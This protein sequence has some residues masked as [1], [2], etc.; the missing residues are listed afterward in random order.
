MIGQE[1]YSFKARLKTL[2]IGAT[3][4]AL[5]ITMLLIMLQNMIIVKSNLTKRINAQSNIIADHVAPA[6]IFEDLTTAQ[7]LLNA[8]R[9]ESAI[10]LARVYNNENKI[11]AEYSSV[12]NAQSS[13]FDKNIKLIELTQISK[14]VMY[15][16][17]A[18][19]EVKLWIS[20]DEL[21]VQLSK[22]L[23]IA[24]IVL[25]FTL[26]L[27]SFGATKML[28]KIYKPI[29]DLSSTAR[30]VS[31]EKNYNLRAP[32][33]DNDEIGELS[34]DFNEML[35]QIQTRDKNLETQ[36]QERTL[37]LEQ[38]NIDLEQSERL[39]KTAF[40]SASIG[41]LLVNEFGEIVQVNQALCEMLGY[42]EEIILNLTIVDIAYSEDKRKG[43]EKFEQLV[44]DELDKF[45]LNK[46]YSTQG[47]DIIWGQINVSAVRDSQGKFVYAIAQ[48]QDIT[49]SYLLSQKL[50]YQASHDELTGLINRYEFE[51]R[52]TMLLKRAQ[53][54]N[55][56]HALL[57]I[58]LDQFKVINDTCGHVAGDDLLRKVSELMLT[59][60]RQSDTLAR[61]GGDEFG[62]LIESCNV[63]DAIKLAEQIRVSIEEVRF[64]WEGKGFAIG[65]SIG[66]I[67]IDQN[68][69]SV[70]DVLK[71]ADAA[72]YAAKDLGRNQV[73]LYGGENSNFAYRQGEM[74]WVSKIT[75]AFENSAFKLYA[76]P[77]VKISD[78][79]IYHYEILLRMFD[80]NANL[81]PPGAFIPAAER[82]NLMGKID[83]WV[84]ENTFSWLQ[85][86]RNSSLFHFS[87]NLSGMNIGNADFLQ[88]VIQQFDKYAI[89]TEQICFEITETAAVSNL[90]SA[91]K[92]ILA[93]QEKG[94]QFSLDDFGSGVSSFAYLK[95]FAVDYLK[96]DG[97]FVKDILDDP[98]D[99]AMVKSINEI[100]HVMGKKT[101][102][103]F[104]ESKE[105]FNLL[106]EL[107]VDYAQGYGVGKPIPIDEIK[108]TRA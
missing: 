64:S 53:A 32:I 7:D 11:F 61:L 38:K 71:A 3:G 39:F 106:A 12:S 5:A 70:T 96:I 50:T 23:L 69:T 88:F 93:L 77:I 101:I 90:S 98:I 1:N 47:G 44:N 79:K 54:E 2:V 45:A 72:C 97:V 6:L 59:K 28:K 9:H 80:D 92:F 87:I 49:E 108:L 57:Y 42:E 86:N 78:N 82:Y 10:V 15:N 103:E 75:E 25:I 102:A 34:K 60:I 19:G 73:H 100:S 35:L 81:I 95:N 48:L 26:L 4:I 36:V 31:R 22:V 99:K 13:A 41:V 56:N 68:L 33:S 74:Q 104:V 24:F 84:I 16:N 37:Q 18:I 55:S 17:N 85:E 62:L 14:P 76:Q 21:L 58:D 67:G 89:N 29:D 30:R 51:R 65:S 40:E 94:C 66:I 107:G 8:F 46:R 52:L 43:L 20:N 91:N 63:H 83:R 27:V 105:I